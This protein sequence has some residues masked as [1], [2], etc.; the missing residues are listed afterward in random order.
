MKRETIPYEAIHAAAKTLAGFE[1]DAW[2]F[3]PP[4]MD[5]ITRSGTDE[6]V[7]LRRAEAVLEAADHAARTIPRTPPVE[8]AP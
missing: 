1:G 8:A 6:S 5:G 4:K 7:Y 3:E 2:V